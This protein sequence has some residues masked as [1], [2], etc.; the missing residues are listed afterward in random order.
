[1]PYNQKI[2]QKEFN[3][4][5][6]TAWEDDCTACANE[7]HDV[8]EPIPHDCYMCAE[9]SPRITTYNYFDLITLVLTAAFFIMVVFLMIR[10]RKK[11]YV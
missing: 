10:K 7:V 4:Y 1:M 3:N 11:K 5:D 9:Y 8:N 6:L 2:E